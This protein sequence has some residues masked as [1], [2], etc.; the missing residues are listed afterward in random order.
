MAFILCIL[1]L[2]GCIR[3]RHRD[4][5][6]YFGSY[7]EAEAFYN[8]KDYGKALQRYQAYIDENPEGNL[9]VISQYYMAKS[10]AALG[11]KDEAAALYKK[12]VAEH[13]DLVWANFSEA[14]L[15]ELQ[16]AGAEKQAP[17]KAS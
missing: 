12:I 7:S 3:G 11:H 14:Q 15:K 17:A 5:D 1:V 9:A 13:P 8:R 2:S 16:S 4:G 6:F 10:H